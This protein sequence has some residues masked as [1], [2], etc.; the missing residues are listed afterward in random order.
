MQLLCVDVDDDDD[1]DALLDLLRCCRRCRRC[2]CCCQ[3]ALLLPREWS[4]R[5]CHPKD[6][7]RCMRRSQHCL[8]LSCAA[9]HVC[10]A[11]GVA[12]VHLPPL[13]VH[14]FVPS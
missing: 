7:Q 4:D 1:S 6:G 10:D 12:A 2:C 5:A 11:C 8:S 13:Q 3:H 9:V 14:F